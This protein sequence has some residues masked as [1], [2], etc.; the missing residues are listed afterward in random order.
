MRGGGMTAEDDA[1]RIAAM[2][3]DVEAHPVGHGDRRGDH[4]VERRGGAE[5]A[6]RLDSDDATRGELGGDEGEILLVLRAPVAAVN[7]DMHGRG[8]ARGG[9]RIDV[10]LAQ[11][12]VAI[13]EVAREGERVAGPRIRAGARGLRVLEVGKGGLRV[14]PELRLAQIEAET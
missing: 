14:E 7:V 2:F 13:G 1:A 4:A 8:T 10:E 5:F 3:C 9:G 11:R 12:V 6:I